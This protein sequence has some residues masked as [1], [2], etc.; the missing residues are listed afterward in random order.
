MSK[1]DQ[2]IEKAI[3]NSIR[4]DEINN[5]LYQA[6]ECERISLYDVGTPNASTTDEYG[7]MTSLST[8]IFKNGMFD[9]QKE[10][11]IEFIDKI[12]FQIPNGTKEFDSYEHENVVLRAEAIN[13][14]VL[15]FCKD[16]S[17]SNNKDVML[18]A[19][20][21]DGFAIQFASENLRD[22][23]ELAMIAI[24]NK[25]RSLEHLSPRLQNDKDVVLEAVKKNPAVIQYASQSLQDIAGDDPV[26]GI[27]K[28]I[29]AEEL[30]TKLN[31]ACKPKVESNKPKMKI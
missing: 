3:Q 4:E 24:S 26:A 13:S 18:A 30:H 23:R 10:D 31:Q 5:E 20:K 7:N 16:K 8:Y 28:A 19:V 11:V 27:G 17:F 15:D 14:N 29:K 9:A 12:G 2:I 6:G 1:V 22:D 25:A 21:D